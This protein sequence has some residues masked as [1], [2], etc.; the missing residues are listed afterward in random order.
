MYNSIETLIRD[1]DTL[2]LPLWK[3]IQGEDCEEQGITIEESN[4]RMLKLYEAMKDSD[5][6]YDEKAKS[7]SGLIGGE[8][9]L[10]E[11][12]RKDGLLLS[13]DFLGRIMER[14]LKVASSN[15]CMKRI[16]AAPTA[17]SCGVVP[18]VLLTVQE[19]FGFSDDKMVEALYVAAGIGGVIASRATLSG[20]EGGCQAEIGSA[21]AMAAA[22]LTY[23]KGGTNQQIVHASALALKGLLGLACDPVAGLV[24]VPCVKRNVIGAIN[25]VTST[26]MSLSGI[27]SKVSPD[28]VFDAMRNI[29]HCMSSDIRETGIGGLAGTKDGIKIKQKM[30]NQK[31][32]K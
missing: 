26:D 8:A 22:A 18:A 27:E 21:S 15:A 6:Q 30:F 14:A 4:S 24:E 9:S 32:L 1:A 25:A 23:L 17:G 10:I 29:G 19:E 2:D 16:V 20:A 31:P 11:K 12:R 3:V 28:Q 5:T 7:A 13:G